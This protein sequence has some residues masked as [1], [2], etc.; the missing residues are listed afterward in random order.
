MST[1]TDVPSAESVIDPP[2]D[3]SKT[4]R[5]LLVAV[6]IASAIP[7]YWAAVRDARNG[8]YP[9]LDAAATV[10][11]SRAVLSRHPP[12]V[13]MWS[14]GS[15]WAGHE[16]HFPGAIQLYLLAIPVHVLGNTWGTLL[17][18]ATINVAWVLLAGWLLYRRLGTNGAL[19]GFLFLM[20]FIWSLGSENLIDPRPMEMVTIPFLCF[21]IAVWMVAS[22]DIDAIPGLMVV[23]NY[24]YLDHL[25]MALQVPVIGLCAVAGI[26]VW[27]R[28]NRTRHQDGDLPWWRPLRRRLLQG[29][30]IT[31]VMWLPSLIQE[32]RAHPGN[33]TLLFRASG[34]NRAAVDSF[35][36]AYN[37]VIRLIAVPK[38]WFRGRFDDAS[39]VHAIGTIGAPEIIG[40][41]VVLVLLCVLGF[42][43]WRQRDPIALSGVGVIVVAIAI[44]LETVIQAPA[45]WGLNTQYLRSLWGLAAFVWLVLAV[46]VFR[47][48]RP[49]FQ[50]RIAA[51][52]GIGA[53]LVVIPSLSYA[54]YGSATDL[55]DAPIAREVN[56]KS[57]PELVGRGKVYVASKG[58][59]TSQRF[60]SSLLLALDT[61]GVHYCVDHQTAQQ[62]GAQHDCAAKSDVEVV[63]AVGERPKVAGGKLLAGVP[64]LP[65]AERKEYFKAR[66]SVRRWLKSRSSIALNPSYE[67]R[68]KAANPAVLAT[69]KK[70][71][72]PADGDLLPLLDRYAFAV[73]TTVAGDHRVDEHGEESDLRGAEHASETVRDVLRSSQEGG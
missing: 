38:F 49:H 46:I 50:P 10:L 73:L 68:V 28:R 60:A 57:V 7:F 61:A 13:G 27:A 1:I 3:A 71:L 21:L 17:A 30:V 45:T 44:S 62:Y 65:A 20:L 69:M 66:D 31:V 24:L 15:G 40:G 19:L 18:M 23:A 8:F 37:S 54:D 43:A 42:L 41:I 48:V 58:D 4:N 33:L 25:V 12:L 64:L 67:R 32:V 36:I 6:A 39:Y 72:N 55:R 63:V 56:Q 52:A 35:P 5:L 2:R 11:R 14:S 29:L 53:L 22:G 59:F 16:I 26:V 70:Y 9:T 47:L 51:A 34:Q